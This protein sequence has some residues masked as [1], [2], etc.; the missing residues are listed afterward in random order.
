MTEPLF[1][2]DDEIYFMTE[3]QRGSQQCVELSRLGIP[4]KPTRS[5]RPLVTRTAAEK[6]IGG[7]GGGRDRFVPPDLEALKA[8]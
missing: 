6:H 3:Y 4:F 1:L 5:G 8:V 7:Y 2:T